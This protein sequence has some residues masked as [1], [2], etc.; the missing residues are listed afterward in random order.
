[1]FV[2]WFVPLPV[3]LKKHIFHDNVNKDNNFNLLINAWQVFLRV[4][5]ADRCYEGIYISAAL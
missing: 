1:M 3:G 4:D 5:G 2:A